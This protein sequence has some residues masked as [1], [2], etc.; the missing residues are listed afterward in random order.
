MDNTPDKETLIE[1]LLQERD[2]LYLELSKLREIDKGALGKAEAIIKKKD[3][4][5]REK[6]DK[7]KQLTDQLSWYRRKFWKSSSERFIPQDPNQRRIS[8]T[9]AQATPLCGTGRR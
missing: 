7:I 8:V 6:D 5:L 2:D 1:A 4:K 3:E 9:C